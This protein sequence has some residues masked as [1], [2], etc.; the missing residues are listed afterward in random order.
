MSEQRRDI[1]GRCVVG[2]WGVL[3]TDRRG[4]GGERGAV[5]DLGGSTLSK[6]WRMIGPQRRLVLL[7]AFLRGKFPHTSAALSEFYAPSISIRNHTSNSPHHLQP[8]APHRLTSPPRPPPVFPLN[9]YP[10]GLF[11]TSPPP[12]PL[13]RLPHP[14]PG[15]RLRSP[16]PAIARALLGRPGRILRLL[17]AQRHRG[18][19]TGQRQGGRRLRG[20]REG[21]REG[22][23]GQL[24]TFRSCFWEPGGRRGGEEGGNRGGEGRR[25]WEGESGAVLEWDEWLIGR[26]GLQVTYF[27]QRRVMEHKKMQTL[28]QLAREGATELPIDQRKSPS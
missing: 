22:V 9:A 18:Q 15:R 28:E 1:P 13:P 11:S 8:A 17:G 16:G 3:R 10:M 24:G 23:R 2:V 12:R 5:G 20:R 26:W 25:R 6:I 4:F 27:K 21:V 14:L 7:N 19:H